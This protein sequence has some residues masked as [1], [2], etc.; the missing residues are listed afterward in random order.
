MKRVEAKVKDIVE[1]RSFNRLTDYAADPAKTLSN[2][3]FT[4]ITADLMGKWIEAILNVRQGQGAALALAGFRGVGKSHFLSVLGSIA[5]QPELR[6]NITDQ[7]VESVAGRLSRRQTPIVRVHR[8]THPTLLDELKLGISD[9][10]GIP[11]ENLSDS[12]QDLLLKISEISSDLPT[13]LLIDTAL[14]REARVTRDDGS[15][16]SEIS[17]A[18]KAMGIF[19]GLALDDDIAGADGA[20]LSISGNYTIDYLD[21]E[22]LYK[23]VDSHIFAKTDQAMPILQ[24]IY[25]HYAGA[26]P[27]FRWSEQRFMSLYPLHPATLEIAPLI[28]LYL[29]EFA[30][31]GFAAEAGVKILGR[32]AHSLIGIDEV[33][34]AVEKRLRQVPDLKDAFGVLD[35]LD[36]VVV[37]KMPV[38]Q[39]LPAK[40]V[41][42]GLFMLSLNGQGSTSSDIAAA[43]LVTTEEESGSHAIDIPGLLDA[44]ALAMPDAISRIERDDSP[45]YCFKLIAEEDLNT[46]LEALSANVSPEVVRSILLRQ[47]SD[48]YSDLNIDADSQRSLCSVEWRGSIR[49]GDIEWKLNSD[50]ATVVSHGDWN[51]VVRFAAPDEKAEAVNP[52][53][54]EWRVAPLTPVESETVQRLYTLQNDVE[55]RSQFKEKLPTAMH[56]QSLAVEKIWQRVFF[57]DGRLIVDKGEYRFSEDARRSH[58]LSQLFTV[59]LE[60]V[61]SFRYPEHPTFSKSLGIK[62][63]GHLTAK[64]FGGGT[65]NNADVQELAETFAVPLGLADLRDGLYVPVAADTLHTLPAIRSLLGKIDLTNDAVVSMRDVVTHLGAAPIGLSRESQHVVLSAL[66][67][68]R[69]LEF[70]TSSGN[71]I[72]HRSLDLQILWDDIAGI[73]TPV[74]EVYSEKRLVQWA[75]LITGSK[76]LKS[77]SNPDDRL[78][79]IDTLSGWLT[80][81]REA[82]FLERF[83]ALPDENL[84]S[85]IWRIAAN[86]RKTFGVLASRIDELVQDAI[87]LDQCL[88]SIADLFS[89]S[90]DEYEK[91]KNDL[92]VLRHFTEMAEK[93]SSMIE[94]LALS[95][96]SQDTELEDLKSELL[97][98]TGSAFFSAEPTVNADI[99]RLWNEFQKRYADLYVEKH[100]AWIDA[101]ADLEKLKTLLASDVW[102]AFENFSSLGWFDPHYTSAA[103]GLL[104]DARLRDCRADVR[105]LLEAKPFCSCAFSLGTFDRRR[106]RVARL[107]FVADQSLTAFAFRLNENLGDL[108]DI[109]KKDKNVGPTLSGCLRSSFDAKSLSELTAQE[110]KRVRWAVGQLEKLEDEMGDLGR[111]I[112][113]AP[114]QLDMVS[115]KA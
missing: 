77:L 73:A 11:V 100:D 82:S 21:Q 1:V 3:H 76:G 53:V 57:G 75:R 104:R 19:V 49:H 101:K 40:L 5:S 86:L 55:V 84:N 69:Q 29:Q 60:P 107:E 68:Q 63:A 28:R 106:D 67:A 103:K 83:E 39:R 87:P 42:K 61:F 35:N 9:V 12:L 43:M 52:S 50:D 18:A 58:T 36:H 90:E 74:A 95:E 71:R 6:G 56:I 98:R 34:D 64:F 92:I 46:A 97:V 112:F 41:L 14:G 37:S 88:Q 79:M 114:T 2:Y 81:W 24:E 27:G 62:E 32:P 65:A 31:L 44:F 110:M 91:K 13:L 48:K 66:V 59:M 38:H 70:V 108:N 17:V 15:V 4:D 102:M 78:V 99:Q 115:T 72:N 93:R 89:D 22:H 85:S 30:L 113:A 26:M 105:Q 25:R 94:Y 47:T 96:T 51:V 8:G 111:E 10:L 33:Y 16:L 54:M 109:L 20:N 23:I 80:N 45:R 7:Y